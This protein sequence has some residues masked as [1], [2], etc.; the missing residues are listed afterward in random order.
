MASG[1]QPPDLE[2]YLPKPRGRRAARWCSAAEAVRQIPEGARVFIG[3][4]PAMASQLIDALVDERDRWQRLDIVLPLLTRRLS[5]FEHAGKP[6]HF[7]TTQASPAFKYLW[8]SGFVEVLPNRFGDHSRLLGPDG[9][10][11]VDVAIV[12][13]SD[14]GPD[15][16]VSLGM[17]T[18]AQV[19]PARTAPLV[20]AQVNAKIPYTLGAGELEVE[21]FDALVR[22]DEP[23]RDAKEKEEAP[24]EVS[25]RIAELA[26]SLVA[27]GS[28][29]Q[30]G[31]GSIP[32]AILEALHGRKGL[33]VHSGLIS[34]ACADLHAAGVVEGVMLTA[35][36]MPTARMRHWVHRNPAVCMAPVALTHGAAALAGLQGFV[37]LNSAV[38]VALDGS[39]NSEMANGEIISGPGGA[40]DYGFGASVSNGGRF[41]VALRAT[42]ARGA[43]SRIVSHIQPPN[44]TTLPAYLADAIVTEHGIAEV[45]GLSASARAEA[46]INLAAPAHRDALRAR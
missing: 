36:V 24:D 45:R 25:N 26:A 28:V 37:A 6:F 42:A 44:P 38:E 12:A 1:L 35:E 17:S 23:C 46:I 19:T 8:S 30:F 16:R 10:L 43:V 40:P 14:P 11:P 27:D 33:R 29:I 7:I 32:D 34:Q 3:G 41:V 2:P 4:G 20:I 18:G 13:V 31:I 22:G 15:G 5:L 9:P 21:W 39:M